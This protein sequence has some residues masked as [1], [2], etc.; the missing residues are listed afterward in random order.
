M[1]GSMPAGVVH[2]GGHMERRVRV[3]LS[4]EKRGKQIGQRLGRHRDV[5]LLDLHFCAYVHVHVSACRA[6]ALSPQAYVLH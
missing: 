3:G 2:H 5:P 6:R 4:G 1:Q